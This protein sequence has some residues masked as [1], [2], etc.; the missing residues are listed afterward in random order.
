M[1]RAKNYFGLSPWGAHDLR[2]TCRTFM[3]EI[4][5]ITS[6][7]AETILNHAKEGT[8]KNYY[9]HKNTEANKK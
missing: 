7:T 8:K 9:H 5:G 2:R 3:S 1:I 6:K 4:D